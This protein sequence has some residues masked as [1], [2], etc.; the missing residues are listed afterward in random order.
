MAVVTIKIAANVPDGDRTLPLRAE[1]SALELVKGWS[2]E[3]AG[4]VDSKIEVST[5]VYVT[6]P[7]TPKAERKKRTPKL[8]PQV[9]VQPLTPTQVQ[10]AVHDRA[11]AE[12]ITKE[13][14][15]G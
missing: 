10:N 11:A 12:Y 1:L 8:K 6:V 2:L 13:A 3:W 5:E 15:R 4:G 9:P 14:Y 7:P